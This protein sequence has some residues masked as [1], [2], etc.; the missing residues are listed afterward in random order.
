[1][2]LWKTTWQAFLSAAISLGLGVWGALGLLS[3]KGRKREISKFIFL[4]PNF[5]PTLFVVLAMLNILNPF[6]Y[7][8]AGIV[9]TH[10]LIN[11]GLVAYIL[12]EA[13]ENRLGGIVELCMIEGASRFRVLV[14]G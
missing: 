6:P 11:T 5:L 9:I 3:V 14:D 8:I 12:S 7:G 2:V 4:L 13:F 1:L 10:V